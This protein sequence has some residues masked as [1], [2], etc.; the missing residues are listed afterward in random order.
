[1]AISIQNLAKFQI[2][3]KCLMSKDDDGK[4]EKDDDNGRLGQDPRVGC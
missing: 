2:Y 1:M 4:E 3:G